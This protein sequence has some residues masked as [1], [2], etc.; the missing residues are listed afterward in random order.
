MNI[1]QRIAFCIALSAFA[2]SAGAQP[3]VKKY[4][5][6]WKVF[7]D[8]VKKELPKSALAQAKKIY[9]L[10]RKENQDAQ[11]IKSVI[12]ILTTQDEI[13]EE[14]EL[15]SV[16]D[17]EKE[18]A[19][20]KEPVTSLLYSLL[21]DVYLGY[22]QGHRWQ[23]Y[24]RTATADFKKDDPATWT[25]EDFHKKISELYLRSIREEKT[26][27][28]IRLETFDAIVIKG[29]VRHLRPTLFDLLAHRALAYFQNDER[30]V[31]K[32]AYH[33][34]ID[35]ASAFAPAAEFVR[36]NFISNDSLS[37]QHKA[38]LLFQR[39]IAFHLKDP[40][41]DALLDLDILRLEFVKTNSVHPEKDELYM[42]ALDKITKQY[43]SLSAAS[44]AGYLM[45]KYYDEKASTYKAYGD[46]THRLDRI[47]ALQICQQVIAQKDSSEGKYNCINLLNSLKEQSLEFSIEKVN[48]PGQPFRAFVTYR[49]FTQLYLRVIKADENLKKQLENSYDSKYWTAINNA[50]S[51]KSWQQA[52]PATTDMQKHGVEIKA[53]GL[54]VGEYMLVAANSSDAGNAKTLLGA[55]LFYVSAISFVNNH[56]AYFVMNRDNGQPLAAASVQT[57]EQKYDY[58]ISK[59]KKE[60]GKLYKTD[61]NGHFRIERIKDKNNRYVNNSYFLDISYQTD[62]LFMDDLIYDYYYYNTEDEDPKITTSIHLFL[63][64]S[65]YRPGQTVFFKGIVLMQNAGEKT[66]AV[67]KDYEATVILKDANRKE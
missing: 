39:L 58:G 29:N 55:R 40:K 59:Y 24:N 6:E 20:S 54:P 33:F 64:R 27:Q 13:R 51:V 28:Q 11:V 49:N 44:Q 18:I 26:L 2:L 66:A 25:A 35:Q 37:L 43:G 4:E 32:P 30:D 19:V 23:F 9:E 42:D 14:N 52:L 31:S 5:K 56:E 34:E 62:H 57:W 3:P 48:L 65:I 36:Q 1:I 63:D 17:I 38:L 41:P 8:F 46:S 50:P 22:Y 16:S 12:Y 61:A 47:K 45:A 67:R 60:K 7:D 10:A 53:E 21:A 15:L